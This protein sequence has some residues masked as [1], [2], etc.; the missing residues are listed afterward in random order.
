[1][2]E[3]LIPVPIILIIAATAVTNLLYCHGKRSFCLL[4]MCLLG[5][6]VH[7]PGGLTIAQCLQ[8]LERLRE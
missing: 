7:C 1:M 4:E 2:I 8:I 5:G 3:L 6:Q